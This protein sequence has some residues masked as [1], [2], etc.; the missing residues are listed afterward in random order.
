MT[1][2]G[3]LERGGGTV[4]VGMRRRGDKGRVGIEREGED[5]EGEGSRG[6]GVGG[7]HGGEMP[8][9]LMQNVLLLRSGITA[10][11]HV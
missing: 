10:T 5:L 6:K 9:I 11:V 8:T 4:E 1:R 2:S 7:S 3:S